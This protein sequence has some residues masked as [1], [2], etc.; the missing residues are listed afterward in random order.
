MGPGDGT[1][2]I[3]SERRAE[4]GDAKEQA[5]GL[6]VEDGR[7]HAGESAQ[8]RVVHASPGQGLVQPYWLHLFAAGSW[9]LDL[10]PSGPLLSVGPG[11]L[12]SGPCAR[13]G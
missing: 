12:P 13:P 2:W 3:Q 4:G 6:S 11:V 5:L 8:G 10:L 7:C 1:A 9:S